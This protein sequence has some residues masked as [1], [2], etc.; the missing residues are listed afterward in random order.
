MLA[1]L[2]LSPSTCTT[3]S[4]SF[5]IISLISWSFRVCRFHQGRDWHFFGPRRFRDDC[6]RRQ[7]NSTPHRKEQDVQICREKTRTVW[8]K[9]FGRV[10]C[11]SCCVLLCS[12]LHFVCHVVFRFLILWQ[13]SRVI[14]HVRYFVPLTLF[15]DEKRPQVPKEITPD[16]IQAYLDHGVLRIAVPKPQKKEQ[17]EILHGNPAKINVL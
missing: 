13:L 8:E 5:Q 11:V 14:R 12:C 9:N 4:P 10:V 3:H 6:N 7:E 2:S 15:S 1:I 17:K 16:K